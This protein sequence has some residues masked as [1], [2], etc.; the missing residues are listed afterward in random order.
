VEQ[1]FHG[2]LPVFVAFPGLVA[3]EEQVGEPDVAELG[4]RADAEEVVVF[5]TEQEHVAG[6]VVE[7]VLVDHVYALSRVNKDDLEVVVVM[8][9]VRP[10]AQCEQRNVKRLILVEAFHRAGCFLLEPAYTLVTFSF[11]YATGNAF[12][13]GLVFQPRHLVLPGQ[14]SVPQTMTLSTLARDQ[15]DALPDLFVFCFQFWVYPPYFSRVHLPGV[16]RS[17]SP[18]FQCSNLPVAIPLAAVPAGFPGR[19][20]QKWLAFRD[21]FCCLQKLFPQPKCFWYC[22]I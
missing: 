14:L 9:R 6:P 4:R 22:G 13:V 8:Q 19:G 7:S 10:L 15:P 1:V 2:L 3:A 5:G 11:I 12:F 17:T 16:V 21:T 20:L 18:T